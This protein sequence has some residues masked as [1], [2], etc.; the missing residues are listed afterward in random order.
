MAF[1]RVIAR[2]RSLMMSI[3]P[4][5]TIFPAAFMTAIE[6]LSLCIHADIFAA[7][8]NRAFLSGAVEPN[9]QNLLQKGRPLYC[10]AKPDKWFWAEFSCPVWA[11]ISNVDI[12]A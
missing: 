10:V 12:A 3:T 2:V 4:S 8:H 9:T 1:T 5:I 6:I 11:F 7:S